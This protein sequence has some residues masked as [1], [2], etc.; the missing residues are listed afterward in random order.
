MTLALVVIIGINLLGT[1]AFGEAEFWFASIKILTIVGLIIMSFA[2]DVGA[3]DEGVLGFR[4]WKNPGPFVQYNGV[5]GY[6]DC[7]VAV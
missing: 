6:V 4:Y 2:L 3:G 7:S 5:T 1:R